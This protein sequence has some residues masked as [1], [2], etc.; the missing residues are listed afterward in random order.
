MVQRL[1]VPS[2]VRSPATG[3]RLSNVK[4]VL[5]TSVGRIVLDF[6]GDTVV[7]VVLLDEEGWEKQEGEW[8]DRQVAKALFY[9]A[10]VPEE[11]ARQIEAKVLREYEARGGDPTGEWENGDT[12]ATVVGGSLVLGFLGTFA[13]GL[14]TIARYLWN[15]G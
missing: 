8:G 6:Y 5:D 12:V 7:S 13:V 9:N 2:R 10:G 3:R 11:E 15:R 1:A 14:A 4:H